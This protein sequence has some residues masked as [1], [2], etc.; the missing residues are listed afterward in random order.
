MPKLAVKISKIPDTQWMPKRRGNL[1]DQSSMITKYI[2]SLHAILPLAAVTEDESGWCVNALSASLE[3][4]MDRTTT[5][6]QDLRAF[7]DDI[8]E[9]KSIHTKKEPKP[10]EIRTGSGGGTGVP[11]A[12]ELK[13]VATAL[14][15][16][17]LT[18]SIQAH[19]MSAWVEQWTE[20]KENSA[21]SKQGDKSIIAYLKTCISRDILSAI[22]YKVKTLRKICL[23]QFKY[24]LTQKF[25]QKLY[26]S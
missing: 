15:P 25:T 1:W 23:M 20:F 19:D 26:A 8:E 4:C 22:D 24:I 16:V 12:P 6:N 3:Q 10:E 14:K 5:G 13:G 17:E 21:F 9:W 11:R 18:S 2:D 7:I